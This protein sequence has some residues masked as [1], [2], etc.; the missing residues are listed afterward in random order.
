MRKLLVI[1]ILLVI[2]IVIADRALLYGAESELGKRVNQEYPMDSEPEVDIRGIPFL[3]Q[4]IS[5][6]YSE[7]T[8][9]TGAFTYQDIQF[10][11]VDVTLHDVEAPLSDMLSTPSATAGHAEGAALLPYSELQR[12]LPEGMAIEQEGGEPRLAGDLPI[13][14]FSVPVESGI[15][16]SVEDSV[17]TVTPTEVEVGEAAIDVSGVADQLAFSFPVDGLPFDLQISAVEALPNGVQI[18]V[19]G[20]DVPI[21]G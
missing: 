16:I 17:L 20:S 12:R 5:G 9:V 21:A 6:E 1:L 10:E 11:R 2:A 13:Q 3:T 14:G 19:E 8:M 4:A 18:S 7:I 15:E